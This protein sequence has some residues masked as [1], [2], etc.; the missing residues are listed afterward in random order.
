MSQN[1]SA[2]PSLLPLEGDRSQHAKAQG[3]GKISDEP[4][5]ICIREQTHPE[6]RP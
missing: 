1:L 3:H 4:I 6:D 5:N 2:R